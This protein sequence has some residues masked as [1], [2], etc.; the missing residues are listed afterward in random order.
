MD[1]SRTGTGF[2][3]SVG[4]GVVPCRSADLS[5]FVVAD[6]SGPGM[7]VSEQYKHSAHLFN[8]KKQF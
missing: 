2:N 8:R 1:G 3:E 6:Q 5:L 4:F 7:L